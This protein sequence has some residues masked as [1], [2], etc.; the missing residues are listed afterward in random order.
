MLTSKVLDI[1]ENNDITI[2]K[3]DNEWMLEW[4][5]NAGENMVEYVEADND[6]DFVGEFYRI[7]DWFDADEHAEMWIEARGKV[8]GVPQTIRELIADADDIQA[9]LD[10]VYKELKTSVYGN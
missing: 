8:A 6:E 9:F 5:S 1:L 4:Y 7:D 3:S 10:K 2:K